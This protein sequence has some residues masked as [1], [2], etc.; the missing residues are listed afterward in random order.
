MVGA[1]E[2]LTTRLGDQ[3]KPLLESALTSDQEEIQKSAARGLAKLAGL[4]DPVNFVLERVQT[5]GFEG[6][7]SPQ[8]IVYC[9]FLFDA[10]VCNGGIM[11]FFGNSS[12]DHAVDT[13]EA[14]RILDHPDAY[15]ALNAAMN[16]VGPLSR[17]P[18]RDMRLAAFEDR[19]DDLKAGFEPLE[20]A[21][22]RT[23]GLLWQRMLLY[24]AA[25][26]DHFRG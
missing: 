16:L 14:L 13:L 17:E 26:G 23:K 24:A 22:Y 1:L 6:L 4:D 10:E 9:A 12:G 2:A 19:Y 11:Q 7:T 20:T 21:Y 18:D 15:R 8:R 3:V 5:V 25:N